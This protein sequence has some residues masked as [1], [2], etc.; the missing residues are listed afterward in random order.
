[1]YCIHHF[2]TRILT[3]IS[4]EVKHFKYIFSAGIKPKKKKRKE[5]K[6][7]FIT[8]QI[9]KTT[10]EMDFLD[11]LFTFN[12]YAVWSLKKPILI[13]NLTKAIRTNHVAAF[14]TKMVRACRWGTDEFSYD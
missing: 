11:V 14:A 1:M 8:L 6:K 7:N 5:K 2:L 3:R 13:D 4:Y 10:E 9:K 12:F